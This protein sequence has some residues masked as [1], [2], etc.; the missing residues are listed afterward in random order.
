MCIRDRDQLG[1]YS[2]GLRE[3]AG[4]RVA[5]GAVVIAKADGNVQIRMLNELEMRGCEVRWTERNHLYQEMLLSG[6]VM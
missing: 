1:A 4:I 5:A 3:R 2:L 6:E